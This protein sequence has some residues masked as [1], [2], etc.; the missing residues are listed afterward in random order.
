M[1]KVPGITLSIKVEK[2]HFQSIPF[3]ATSFQK[4]S[5]NTILSF[6]LLQLYNKNLEKT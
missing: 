4:K 3:W 2:L 6:M 5:F 1:R